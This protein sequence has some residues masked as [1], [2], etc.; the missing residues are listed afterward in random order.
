[1]N[2]LT[3]TRTA[4]RVTARLHRGLAEDI[5]RLRTNA[6]LSVSALGRA[7]GVDPGY[8]RR[9]I[10]GTER[11][12]LHTYARLAVALGADLTSRLYPN[13]GP[14]VRDG[15]QARMLEVLLGAVHPRWQV[16]TEVA[17]RRPSRGWIDAVLHE[18]RERVLVTAELQSEL[19]RLEQLVRWSGEK[20][21]SLPSWDGWARLDAE[22]RTSQLLLVRRTRTTRAVAAE[23]KQQLRVAFPRYPDDALAALAGTAPRP[24]PALVWAIVDG[25]EGRL[26]A[27][28]RW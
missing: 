3:A 20:A 21:A 22:P 7:S 1:V 14:L 11:P 13:T 25:R 6:G 5:D 23:F 12:S 27:G 15:H 17:V 16:H 2:D 9:I 19:R 10:A 28:S 26:S 4:T 18:P 24:G 8:L